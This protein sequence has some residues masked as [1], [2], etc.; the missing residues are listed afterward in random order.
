MYL[1]GNFVILDASC[2]VGEIAT[3]VLLGIWNWFIFMNDVINYY[4]Y[5]L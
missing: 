3:L 4:V 1:T 5:F 2:K